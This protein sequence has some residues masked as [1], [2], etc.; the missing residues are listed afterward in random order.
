MRCKNVNRHLTAFLDGELPSRLRE[1]MEAHLA[2]CVNCQAERDALERVRRTLDGMEAPPFVTSL[3]ADA[4][5][6]RA[7]TE[8]R[9]PGDSPGRAEKLRVRPFRLEAVGLRPAIALAAGLAV[10][11]LW[12]VYPLLKSLPLPTDREMFIAERMELFENLELIEDLP[13][14]ERL[15]LAEG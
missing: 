8:V 13:L 9:D 2:D 6:E 14:V 1:R 4:I 12:A 10:M 11:V 3:S 5:L 15:E 7:R